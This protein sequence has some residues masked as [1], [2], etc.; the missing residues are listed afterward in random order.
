MIIWCLRPELE[1]G[2]HKLSLDGRLFESPNTTASV[3]LAAMNR[4]SLVPG[5]ISSQRV[6]QARP[7]QACTSTKSVN[8]SASWLGSSLTGTAF[9]AAFLRFLM[10]FLTGLILPVR[11]LCMIGPD[12]QSRKAL[13]LLCCLSSIMRMVIVWDGSVAFGRHERSTIQ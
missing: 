6:M 5:T 2:L 7:E 3:D 8:S 12:A 10:L 1:P 9:L 13:K 11:S 4:K